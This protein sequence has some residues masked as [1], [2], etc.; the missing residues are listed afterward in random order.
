MRRSG[1]ISALAL[2]GCGAQGGWTPR[3]HAPSPEATYQSV[4]MERLPP[5][6]TSDTIV[7]LGIEY[8]EPGPLGAHYSGAQFEVRSGSLLLTDGVRRSWSIGSALRVEAALRRAGYRVRQGALPSSDGPP[9]SGARFALIGRVTDL[10]VQSS[11]STG[12]HQVR[13]ETQ[14]AWEV[15]DLAA[16]GSVFGRRTF[17]RAQLPD[18]I[19]GSVL[20]AVDSAL[21]ALVADFGYRAVLMRAAPRENRGAGDAAVDLGERLVERP[22]PGSTDV[23]PLSP[24]DGNPLS[25]ADLGVRL[26]SGVV[27]LRGAERYDESAFLLTRDGLALTTVR[28]VRGALRLWVR[29]GSGVERPARVLRADQNTGVALLHV[30]CP[31]PC[32]TVPWTLEPAAA[33][34]AILV[35]RAPLGPD[36]GHLL[37]DG[38]AN[39]LPGRPLDSRFV[40]QV[41]VPLLGGEP[42]ARARDAVVFAIA[43]PWRSQVRGLPLADAFRGL[44]IRVDPSPARPQATH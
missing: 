39:G 41:N 31:G 42:L 43:V 1:V 40:A 37:G 27:T 34:A 17:G 11:G 33:A 19:P 12:P 22:A 5:A 29:F 36:P 6:V 14:I 20:H 24:A 4:S 9:L 23:I 35:V 26:A 13:A 7:F 2:V 44:G 16:G 8:P 15:F 28:A 21:V 30:S 3:Y 10:A 38:Q 32:T 25:T 18:S